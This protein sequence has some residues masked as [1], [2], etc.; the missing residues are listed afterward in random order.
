LIGAWSAG[1]LGQPWRVGDL[2][3]D[4]VL[5]AAPG[6]VAVADSTTVCLYKLASAALEARPR[7]TEIVTDVDNF[8]TDR[9]VLEGL[10]HARGLTLRWLEGDPVLGPQPEHVAA[11]VGP[12][13]ALVALSHVSY[14]TAAIADVPAI[15]RI[16]HD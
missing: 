4:A 16:A 2:L 12:Q 1:W 13:T 7:R 10:A 8:P 3:G 14:R 5:G 6:Q 15:T 11:A 9:Y